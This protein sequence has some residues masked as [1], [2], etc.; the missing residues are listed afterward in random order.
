MKGSG[1]NRTF[2][3]YANSALSTPQFS[4]AGVPGQVVALKVAVALV[5]E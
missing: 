1:S 4:Y 3:P 5:P 2:A